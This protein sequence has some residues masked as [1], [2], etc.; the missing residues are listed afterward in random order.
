M[1][2]DSFI[3]EAARA[4]HLPVF[5]SRVPLLFVNNNFGRE[6]RTQ[7][8]S[9]PPLLIPRI[10]HVISRHTSD[11]DVEAIDLWK[12]LNPGW[13]VMH[14][15]ERI[16]PALLTRNCFNHTLDVVH[17]FGLV[18]MYGGVF[19]DV[20]SI[21]PRQSIEPL[22]FGLA[23]FMAYESDESVTAKIFGAVPHHRLFGQLSSVD[24]CDRSVV[25]QRVSASTQ[26]AELMTSFPDQTF[27]AFSSHVFFTPRTS[28]DYHS[29]FAVSRTVE[30]SFMS[31]LFA[32]FNFP[33]MP[34]VRRR[35]FLRLARKAAMMT[36]T[37]V[38]SSM[39]ITM[40]I[41]PS[42]S[43]SISISL[44]SSSTSTPSQSQSLSSFATETQTQSPSFEG[45]NSAS[46]SATASQ[47]PSPS[48]EVASSNSAS[49]SATP[50]QSESSSQLPFPSS[51]VSESPSPTS[52]SFSASPSKSKPALASPSSTPIASC[53]TPSATSTVG[54][55]A[56]IDSSVQASTGS[57]VTAQVLLFLPFTVVANL[58]FT[59][60]VAR[61]LIPGLRTSVIGGLNSLALPTTAAVAIVSITTSLGTLFDFTFVD[62]L[63]S[64]PA[65]CYQPAYDGS[66]FLP[67]QVTFVAGTG[68]DPFC[69]S[70]VPA[71]AG[72]TSAVVSAISSSSSIQFVLAFYDTVGKNFFSNLNSSDLAAMLRPPT[73][74]SSSN[75]GEGSSGSS[76]RTTPVGLIV[77][78]T[79]LGVV[80]VGAAVVV[81]RCGCS[82][83]SAK[84]GVCWC[85]NNPARLLDEGFSRRSP[86]RADISGLSGV[87]GPRDDRLHS[88]DSAAAAR[89]LTGVL[90]E[91]AVLLQTSLLSQQPANGLAP[92]SNSPA[93]VFDVA[94]TKQHYDRSRGGDLAQ[95][96][97][98][99]DPE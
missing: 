64:D 29:V 11:S 81:W 63:N 26:S 42:T 37:S 59:N 3:I 62:P 20:E 58:S 68:L 75:G 84:R 83:C 88:G 52:Q 45:S 1:Q 5:M 48:S 85:G 82:L 13:E 6:T 98:P 44:T 61:W 17:K 99:L 10:F 91:S 22:L 30:N 69:A 67:V 43:W 65:P 25:R 66:D 19:I 49:P 40:T 9:A 39:T 96:H 87:K 16:I 56:L 41:T 32:L 70:P 46:P 18:W 28:A 4:S 90:S 12:A 94:S 24:S 23:A 36:T 78:V 60:S 38:T 57:G 31:T 34:R 93:D 15:D 86:I 33:T 77:G 47:S 97:D 8:W 51:S 89:L 95:S 27:R 53:I 14:W 74:V 35:G 73:I 21:E 76:T 72:T 55:C 71:P 54:S 7:R 50:T 79:A 80:A 2:V 92:P